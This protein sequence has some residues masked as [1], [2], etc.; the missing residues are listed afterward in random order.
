MV[1]SG[2]NLIQ[3]ILLE[4]IIV[5]VLILVLLYAYLV[6]KRRK[7]LPL[8]GFSE[9]KEKKDYV[10]TVKTLEK[11]QKKK[12][13]KAGT[14]V[15][16]KAYL[17]N[18][19]PTKP[20]H[21]FI[22]VIY[23]LVFSVIAYFIVGNIWPEHTPLVNSGEYTIDAGSLMIFDKLSS[24]YIDNERVLGQKENVNGFE[25]RKFVSEEI[26]NL[27]F[28]PATPLVGDV[29]ATLEID[30]VTDGNSGSN[31]YLNDKAIIP[32]LENYE[33]VKDFPNENAA[34]YVN[35]NVSY[36]KANLKEGSSVEDFV[37]KN[38]AGN[39]VYSFK[40]TSSD[41]VP[42]LDDYK[43]EFTTIDTTFR[44]N[45]KLAVYH[46][47]GNFEIEFTKQDLNSYVGRDEYTVE[48]KD[49]KGNSVFKK[50]Y[51]DDGVTTKT[52]KTGEEQHFEI[53]VNIPR[54]IYYIN[55]IKDSYNEGIDMTLKNIRINSNKILILGTSNPQSSFSFY[56]KIVSQK[57]IGFKYGGKS[58][59][60]VII[61]SG[62]EK[63]DIN[64]D[65]DWENKRYDRI[66][67][68]KG[69]YKFNSPIG[70][71][72]IYFDYISPS[73]ENWFDIPIQTQSNLNNQDIIIIDTNNI[74]VEENKIQYKDNILVNKDTKFK[75]KVLNENKIYLEKISLKL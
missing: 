25:V 40:E 66:L 13:E 3:L 4:S 31:V 67:E 14:P 45:L 68:S 27:V 60:Q 73:K 53:K 21:Y 2:I 22:L 6:R 41:Y 51:K 34:V 5:E 10:K 69:D 18:L 15:N 55:F 46:G 74:K 30:L 19:K 52:S 16:L 33:L 39:S 65:E 17:R 43:Q 35:K 58:N 62:A 50:T 7:L 47:G 70:H 24:F 37:Y 1:T 38:F 9:E 28:K 56:T 26:F 54:G 29:N 36:G 48:I 32:N 8:R 20:E 49:S 61:V 42:V 59:K 71:V 64:L 44:D 63:K 23:L 57:T 11:S 75:M 12:T 72:Y